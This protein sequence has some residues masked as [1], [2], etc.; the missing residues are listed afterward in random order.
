[1]PYRPLRRSRWR[2]EQ[3]LQ[4]ARPAAPP[5]AEV[6]DQFFDAVDDESDLQ[7]SGAAAGE[8]DETSV[9]PYQPPRLEDIIVDCLRQIQSS[10][11]E[12]ARSLRNL[13]ELFRNMDDN[14]QVS[15]FPSYSKNRKPWLLPAS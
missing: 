11:S 13:E 6:G 14:M 5:G 10:T 15:V 12:T 7:R 8:E 2:S 9:V 4:P 1:M 3:V